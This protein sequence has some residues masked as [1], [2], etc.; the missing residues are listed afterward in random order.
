MAKINKVLWNLRQ[1]RNANIKQMAEFV[2]VNPCVWWSWENGKYEPLQSTRER[3]A[4]L[5][6]LNVDDLWPGKA[7]KTM[8][9][10][11][12][13]HAIRTTDVAWCRAPSVDMTIA[14]CEPFNKGQWS[15]VTCPGCIRVKKGGVKA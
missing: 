10:E 13:V 12:I 5:F 6:G 15:D 7:L 2:G 4:N 1:D 11:G 14:R 9:V 3:I 8:T